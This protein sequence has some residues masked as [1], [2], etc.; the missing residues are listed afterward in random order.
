[1]KSRSEQGVALVV[2][3][4][5][6]S[7]ITFMTV[8]FLVI[9]RRERE[10]VINRSNQSDASFA[11]DAAL[12]HV[13]AQVIAQMYIAGTNGN[14]L[15][16]DM[17]VS[18]NF[19]NPAGFQPGLSSYTN[20]NYDHVVGSA[21]PL[22]Q[23]E[24]FQNLTNL[25]ILPRAPVFITT[26]K[27]QQF[28]EFR[29]YLDLNR[30][31]RYDTNGWVPV[32]D[33][34]GNPI[35]FNGIPLTNYMR[36]D[37][38]WIGILD[39][40][41]R[42]HSRSN[43]FVARY[44]FIAL[45][46]G[47]SLDINYIHNQAKRINT[48][49]DGYLRDQGA[50]SWENNLAAFL[51]TLNTNTYAWGGTYQ[52]ETNS[53]FNST[54]NSF[55]DALGIV[56]YRYGGNANNY[57]SLGTILGLYGVIG[58]NAIQNDHIDDYLHGA[59]MTTPFGL[60]TD[61]DLPAFMN[62]PWPG[63]DNTNHFYTSQDLF[64]SDPTMFSFSNRL[65]SLGTNNSTYDRYTFYNLLTQMSM[66]SAP[67]KPGKIHLNYKNI[68]GLSPTNFVAWT[69]LEFF[70]NAADKML[71]AQ[72]SNISITNIPVYN[73]TNFIYSPAVQRILQ[74]AANIYDA[75][76]NRPFDTSTNQVFYPSVFRPYFAIKNTTNVYIAGF[77]E[78]TNRVDY[79]SAPLDLTT[80]AGLQKLRTD[81]KPGSANDNVYGVPYIIG[82]KK[83]FP[84]FN[85]FSMAAIS[86]ITRRMQITKTTSTKPADW[87]YAVQYVVGISNAFGVELWNSYTSSYPRDVTIYVTNEMSMLITNDMGLTYPTNIPIGTNFTIPANTWQGAP[88]TL[89]GSAKAGL[90]LPLITNFV[91]VPDSVYSAT[92]VGFT[93]NLHVGYLP[94]VPT[95]RSPQW[96]LY[97]TN[98]VRLILQ[99]TATKRII[100]YVQLGGMG[101]STNIAQYLQPLGADINNHFKNLWNTNKLSKTPPNLTQGMNSQVQVSL[102]NQNAAAADW[103]P[104]MILPGGYNQSFEIDKFRAFYGLSPLSP[105]AY[106]SAQY[107]QVKAASNNIVAQ[108]PFTPTA[109]INDYRTWQ[110]NDPLVHY[111]VSDLTDL[112]RAQNKA[113]TLKPGSPIS[114]NDA[115][116][117][118]RVINTRFQPWGGNPQNPDDL[119][120][121]LA[122]KDPLITR[123]DDWNFPTNKFPNVGWLGRVHR[124]TP[125]QTVYLKSG[126]VATNRWQL[127][128]GI[129]NKFVL[130]SGMTQP[131]NDWALMELFTTAVN[132]NASRG[133]LSVNQANLASWAAILGGVI[134]LTNTTDDAN[135]GIYPQP[136]LQFGAL[137]IDPATHSVALSNIVAGINRSRATTNYPNQMFQ[138]LGDVLSAPELTVNSPFLNLSDAQRKG[139]IPDA[140]YERIPQQTLSLLRLGEP[141][142]V[143]YSYGQSLKPA[144]KSVI[145]SSG[146]YFGVPTNYTI[147]GEVVTRSVVRVDNYPTPGLGHTNQPHV[148]VESYTVLPP[149]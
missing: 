9:S 40:P 46:V 5:L 128:T 56:R 101:D 85:E 77:T 125:W 42:P 10:G 143:I 49:A 138:H 103:T 147:T 137:P 105:G 91:F 124:G 112:Q 87:T 54:G 63:A 108:V 102:G 11:A 16:F 78:V 53:G 119:A 113:L 17:M 58:A 84:N 130:D 148:V 80:P 68:N 41:D 22:S 32:V 4:I 144:D 14:G 127:W 2:T 25:L 23:A 139:G 92:P 37:P 114:L 135:V 47:D 133:Q 70:T 3:L 123:S 88:Q 29:Y 97:V 1:M 134:T 115:L 26:N 30:N 20:V 38:E 76:T 6:L 104:Y 24:F 21:A 57:N 129:D 15:A 107:D 111:T 13:K 94:G 82:A 98:R 64:S 106:T 75:S 39:H 27:N 83:G 72:F 96:A 120:T 74:L 12:E 100:D 34:L 118:L 131:T 149:E 66:D 35:L 50:G 62:T 116:P 36:G 19:I 145:Q 71:R 55:I 48:K 44:A 146:P 110:A 90:I 43:L 61:P 52:Y 73:G 136:P 117:N 109:K 86:Q 126:T 67:D 141:R 8:T 7:V 51:Y 28:A 79:M 18:T 33:N 140:V 89:N 122:Y 45:P 142:Y 81:L 69:A 121:D 93:T 31:G 60:Q 132:E 99:D 65:Y 59:L 95:D